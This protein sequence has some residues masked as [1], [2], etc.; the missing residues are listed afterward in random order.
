MQDPKPYSY[1]FRPCYGS[2]GEFL[3]EFAK[4]SDHPEFDALLLKAIEGIKPELREVKDLWM[5]DGIHYLYDSKFGNF[6]FSKDVWDFAF[7]VVDKQECINEIDRLLSENNSFEKV[8]VVK[9]PTK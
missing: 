2:S 8:E 7:I 9:R 4:G 1:H 6:T 5:F 3:I